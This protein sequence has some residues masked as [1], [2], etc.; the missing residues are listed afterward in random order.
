MHLR[1]LIFAWLLLS[2]NLHKFDLT[3]L[4]R[5]TSG[6]P[7]NRAQVCRFPVYRPA[8]KINEMQAGEIGRTSAFLAHPFS[9]SLKGL[10]RPERFE[11]P[12]PWFVARYSIQLSY[13]R[14]AR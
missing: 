6:T 3:T 9:N 1:F 8:R 10:A 12:T 4:R 13:G 11:L 2:E 5:K 7:R 14:V